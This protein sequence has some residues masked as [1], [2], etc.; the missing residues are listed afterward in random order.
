MAKRAYYVV[1]DEN[2][3]R[4]KLENGRY[5]DGFHRTQ[6]N[7]IKRARKLA[8]KSG[9]AASKVVVNAKE[10]YTRRHIDNP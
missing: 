4:I 7:A 2:K 6:E 5:L 3:W 1:Y 9:T 8:R 10:G